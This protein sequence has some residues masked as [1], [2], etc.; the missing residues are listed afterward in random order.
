MLYINAQKRFCLIVRMVCLE[1]LIAFMSL[2]ISH[3]SRVISAVSIATSVPVPI[4]IQISACARAGASLIPSPHIPIIA[5]SDCSF[6][7]IFAF[8]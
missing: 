3:P 8:S 7:I 4:A 6:F 5:H 1:S 2:D